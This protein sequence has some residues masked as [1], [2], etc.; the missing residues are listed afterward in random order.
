M[1]RERDPRQS[2]HPREN[3]W[4]VGR[5]TLALF[6]LGKYGM[7]AV[8]AWLLW[9]IADAWKGWCCHPN[10]AFAAIAFPME[11]DPS[12][13][14]Q[15]VDITRVAPVL[16]PHSRRFTTGETPRRFPPTPH[17]GITEQQPANPFLNKSASIVGRLIP[18]LILLGR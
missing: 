17:L 14:Q 4:T 10:P 8:V 15:R 5:V 9:R 18:A 6:L 16:R 7:V 2:P 13:F 1:A 3:A 12:L 11:E